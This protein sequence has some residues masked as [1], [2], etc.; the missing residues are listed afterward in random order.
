[1][2][3]SSRPVILSSIAL[4]NGDT[5]GSTR[6]PIFLSLYL[7]ILYVAFQMSDGSLYHVSYRS[8]LNF[9]T[10]CF[11]SVR[12]PFYF[13]RL[14]AKYVDRRDVSNYCDKMCNLLL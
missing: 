1:M 11:V 13:L 9:L 12:A 14:E 4:R 7:E 5:Q 10:F 6:G 2:G 8:V 3:C